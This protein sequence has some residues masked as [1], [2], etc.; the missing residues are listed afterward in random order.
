MVAP[1]QG[2]S[3]PSGERAHGD[4]RGQRSRGEYNES[5]KQLI[6]QESLG[7]GG[8]ASPLPPGLPAEAYTNVLPRGGFFLILF[9]FL[10]FFFLLIF[11]SSSFLL[12]FLFF[13]FLLLV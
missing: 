13:F 7:E 8:T 4:W 10:L 5:S 12:L 6:N 3:V 2:G 1:E 9:L 11:L